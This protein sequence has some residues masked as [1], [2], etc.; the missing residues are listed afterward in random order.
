MNFLNP[1][2]LIA[3]TALIPVIALYFLKLKRE[4]R[5]VPSTLLWKKVIDD[6]QVN[7][8]F[9]RLKYSLLLLLQLLLVAL[10]AFAL[11]RPY[12]SVAGVAG[13]K[14]I[15]LMD[16]S[17]SMATKDVANAQ[18]TRLQAAIDEARAKI[19]DLREGDA[20]MVLAF[21]RDVRRLTDF[22]ADRTI[23]KQVLSDLQPRDVTT[24]AEEAFSVALSLSE[25]TPNSTVLV[26]S[27]GCFENVKVKNDEEAVAGNTEDAE[28]ITA[29]DQINNR[30]RNF[31]FVSYGRETS[32]NVAI[33][34]ITARTRAIRN[35]DKSGKRVDEMETQVFVM[36]E[37]FSPRD[38]NAVLALSL[39]GENFPAKTITLKGRV[40]KGPTLED[41]PSD[42]RGADA[43]RS[44]EIFKLPPGRNGLV[45]ARIEAP[46]DA[47]PVDNTASVV[48]G[49]YEGTQLL[50]VSAP[51]ANTRLNFFLDKAL[52]AMDGLTVTAM[53]PEE[54]AAQWDLKGNQL[55][56]AYDVCIFDECAPKSWTDGG[57]FFI[58]AI[59]P[60]PEF[61][62]EE[63]TLEFPEIVYWDS[64]HPIMRYVTFGNVVIAKAEQWTVPK[65]ARI[66]VQGKQRD[67]KTPRVEPLII[68]VENDRMRVVAT[69]F[70]GF[71]SDWALHSWP[72]FLYNTIPWLSE[73]SPRRRPTAQ[74]TGTP[75]VIPPNLGADKVTIKRPDGSAEESVALS[76]D[77]ATF[78]RAT[79][80]AGVYYVNGLP[81]EPAGRP[82]A[83]NLV[84]R[85][86]S[87]NAA[88]T[89]VQ[90]GEQKLASSRAAIEGKREIWWDII[91]VVAVLLLVEWLVFHRRFGM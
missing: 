40:P 5:T 19:D 37:N 8:P 52:G 3:L 69:A 46:V 70:D 16:T 36:V 80:K 63:G 61:K 29:M 27:D 31:K 74:Q 38:V 34:Q 41:T 51:S 39:D 91:A 24:N 17:A 73:S 83:V 13:Q 76:K 47:M 22:T 89:F 20:M 85:A 33:T 48:V 62:K 59:P 11:A 67:A 50:V 12:L 84:N 35:R 88:Q 54:F 79:D 60:L 65:S 57:A 32:D 21:D 49:G 18:K 58:G 87:D 68:T 7:A 78:V 64:L 25:Q 10:L 45:T 82:Y 9:Q 90:V 28:T 86:E 55:V 71:S 4:Q 53:T 66:I 6:M 14:T 2:A 15:L 72:L 30:L 81:G 77:R 23:L 44:I 43:S 75:L 26:L 1:L 42:G 56:E